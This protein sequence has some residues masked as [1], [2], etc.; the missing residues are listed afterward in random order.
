[1]TQNS[2]DPFAETQPT[3]LSWADPPPR[4]RRTGCCLGALLIPLVLTLCLAGVWL[5]AGGRTN[6]LILGL[7]A[8][9]PGSDV[10]RSDTM[11]LTTFVPRQPYLGM[12]SIPRDLWVTIPGV[13]ENR[14]NTA[15]FFAEAQTPGSGPDAA[16]E[17]VRQNFGVDVDYY[18]RFRFDTFLDVVDLIG[19]V[20]VELPTAMSGYPAGTHHMDSEQALAFV[21]DRS[22]S[23]DFYRM[24]RA[25]IF[26]KSLWKQMMQPEN[27]RQL[28]QIFPLAWE[29]VDTDLPMRKWPML[30]VTLLRVGPDGVDA[31]VITREMTFPFTT[32]GGAQVL[33]PNWD[34]I[35]PVLLEMF[36]Q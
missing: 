25:Q 24:Q 17:T 10:A 28:P 31:R 3:R 16:M 14:I 36:G 20:D 5:F 23:D 18:V 1:M 19:G 33:A 4:K 13:G 34:A 30:A 8:R 27:L 22:G 6:I 35:N 32:E 2:P 15:H 26:I 12:L 9:D 7:D 11:I 29:S 21:R